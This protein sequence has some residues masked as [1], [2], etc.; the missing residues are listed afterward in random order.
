VHAGTFGGVVLLLAT[1]LK[2]RAP[3]YGLLPPVPVLVG[4]AVVLLLSVAIAAT[5]NDCAFHALYR[6]GGPGP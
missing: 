3:E 2:Y 1:P 4:N 6:F 5:V